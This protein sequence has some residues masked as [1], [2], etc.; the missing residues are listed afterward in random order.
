MGNVEF[1]SLVSPDNNYNGLVSNEGRRR[2]GLL[3]QKDGL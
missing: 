2:S 3:D 1:S